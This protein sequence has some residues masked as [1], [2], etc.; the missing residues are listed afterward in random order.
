MPET[1]LGSEILAANKVK[2][3]RDS[4]L[5]EKENLRFKLSSRVD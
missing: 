4:S 2:I 3:H 5:G 1:A